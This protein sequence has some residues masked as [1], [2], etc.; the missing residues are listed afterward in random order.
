MDEACGV[1]FM[2]P[3]CHGTVVC[4]IATLVAETPE[5][6]GSVVLV[7]LRNTD[8]AVHHSVVPVRRGGELTAHA[9]VFGICLV[10]DIKPE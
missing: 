6:Y 7:A 5:D 9:V 8:H 1:E 4:A 10:K 3:A 2:Q